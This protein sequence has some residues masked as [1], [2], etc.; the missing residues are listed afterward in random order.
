MLRHRRDDGLIAFLD[1]H[2][3]NCRFGRTSE[4]FAPSAR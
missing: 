3:T 2:P 1:D 4:E